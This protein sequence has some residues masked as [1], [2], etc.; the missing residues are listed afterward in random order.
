M[1]TNSRCSSERLKLLYLFVVSLLWTW[2]GLLNSVHR[3]IFTRE[4]CNIWIWDKPANFINFTDT[5]KVIQNATLIFDYTVKH[6]K[7]N[8]TLILSKVYTFLGVEYVL[9]YSNVTI[10]VLVNKYR[11]QYLDIWFQIVRRHSI[12][13]EI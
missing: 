8:R 2:C 12:I 3:R 9:I 5:I 6:F 10:T 1:I 4:W 13:S 11:T 7:E